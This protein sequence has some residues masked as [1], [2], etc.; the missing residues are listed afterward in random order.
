M[1]MLN[2]REAEGG[3]SWQ[4]FPWRALPFM[5]HKEHGTRQLSK[6][7]FALISTQSTGTDLRPTCLGEDSCAP[8]LEAEIRYQNGRGSFWGG[9]G[10][11]LSGER[12]LNFW[13]DQLGRNR[14]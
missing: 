2:V 11:P 9:T 8:L 5:A 4:G 1:R 14:R 10:G 7:V 13:A 6:S 3:S 12:L